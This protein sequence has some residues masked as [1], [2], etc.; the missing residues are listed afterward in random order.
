MYARTYTDDIKS[1][2][3]LKWAIISIIQNSFLELFIN[4]V[5]SVQFDNPSSHLIL[6]TYNFVL[7]P[8]LVKY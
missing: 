3:K 4:P 2:D 6:V 8:G 7:L 1:S 5:T